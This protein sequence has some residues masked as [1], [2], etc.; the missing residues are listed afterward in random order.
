MGEFKKQQNQIFYRWTFEIIQK[1]GQTI[2]RFC[3]SYPFIPQIQPFIPQSRLFQPKTLN[4]TTSLTDNDSD[5]VPEIVAK[6][7]PSIEDTIRNSINGP[8]P[9]SGNAQREYAFDLVS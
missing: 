3:P 6:L 8:V 2:V 7:T 1:F 5:V 9:P 4:T